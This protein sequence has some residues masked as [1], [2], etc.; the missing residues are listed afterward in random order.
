MY[1]L[2][3]NHPPKIRNTL[4]DTAKKAPDWVK[5][6]ATTLL[7]ITPQ[8]YAEVAAILNICDTV[9]DLVEYLHNPIINHIYEESIVRLTNA[10]QGA[11]FKRNVIIPATL[12]Y[13]QQGT[14]DGITSKIKCAVIYDKEAAVFNYRGQSKGI[15][16]ADGSAQI[17][18]FQSILENKSLGSQAV[19]FIKKPIW[20]S[21]DEEGCTA[22]LAKFATDTIT[23]EAMR[24]S[25]HS[26]TS[27][28]KLFKQMT[29]LQWTE[30]IDLTKPIQS[31]DI[32]YSTSAGYATWVSNILFGGQKLLYKNQF[33]DIVQIINSNTDGIFFKCKKKTI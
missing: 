15:D 12:Q 26:K 5:F 28:F 22:F 31:N 33:G 17:N 25:M 6:K 10:A 2:S 21:Y 14:K 4:F 18:P 16:S 19:G 9:G 11:Q 27:L 24:A 20:H 30:P 13:C 8:E 7:D 29:N 32:D 23:N 1:S 3:I